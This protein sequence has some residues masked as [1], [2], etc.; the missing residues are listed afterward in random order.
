M[1][2]NLATV[3]RKNPR[4]HGRDYLYLVISLLIWWG[5]VRGRPIW[6]TPS[7]AY[8]GNPIFFL[9]RMAMGWENP[10]ADALSFAGQNISG[11]LALAVPL[12]W[13]FF[14]IFKKRIRPKQGFSSALTHWILLLECTVTNGIINEVCHALTHRARP[15]VYL[16]TATRSA[17]PSHY[18]SF[19]SGHTSFAAV[20]ATCTVVS[21]I[22]E[23]APRK[24][25]YAAVIIGAALTIGTG[26]CRVLSGRHFPSDVLAGA[27]FGIMISLGIQALHRSRVA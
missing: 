1:S 7:P 11:I 10:T 27:L 9:D 15:F 14:K 25:T 20:A 6:I 2:I 16:D 3:F 12:L 13:I 23:Q 21:L 17:D 22:T 4:V 26:V 24:M 8:L 19:Y 18:T 5:A